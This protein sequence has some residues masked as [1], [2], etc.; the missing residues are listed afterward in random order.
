M[1]LS[2]FSPL[3]ISACHRQKVEAARDNEADVDLSPPCLSKLICIKS[4]GM[5]VRGIHFVGPNAGEVIQGMAIALRLGATKVGERPYL[6]L[7]AFDS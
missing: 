1:Y 7:S 3:E 4:E 6:L 2:E 5:R